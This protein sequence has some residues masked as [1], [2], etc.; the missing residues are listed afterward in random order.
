MPLGH[1]SL[2]RSGLRNGNTMD[3]RIACLQSSSPITSSHLTSGFSV[4]T[5]SLK[6]ALSCWTTWRPFGEF[7]LADVDPTAPF[8]FA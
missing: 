4:I 8:A 2:K 7:W 3:S 1:P 5:S 6:D